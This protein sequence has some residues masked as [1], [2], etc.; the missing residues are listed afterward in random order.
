MSL[1]EQTKKTEKQNMLRQAQNRLRKLEQIEIYR[2][3][4]VQ[5]QIKDIEEQKIQE[6]DRF[7]KAEQD[8]RRR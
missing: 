4:K 1:D 6:D 2:T 3:K 8:N 7:R 5:Q